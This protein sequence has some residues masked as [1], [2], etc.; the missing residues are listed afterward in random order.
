MVPVVKPM[1]PYMLKRWRLDMT[2]DPIW[3]FEK[4]V[5]IP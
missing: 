4:S 2:Q 5:A 1:K 3:F